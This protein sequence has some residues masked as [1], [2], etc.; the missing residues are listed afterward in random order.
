MYYILPAQHLQG[1]ANP[2][3]KD[4]EG[5]TPL[6]ISVDEAHIRI[7]EVLLDKSKTCNFMLEI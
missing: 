1:N 3:S 4:S 5:R 2:N 7:I 6:H